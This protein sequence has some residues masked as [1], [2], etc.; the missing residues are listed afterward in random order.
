[1]KADSSQA[2]LLNSLYCHKSDPSIHQ[3][4]AMSHL[5]DLKVDHFVLWRPKAIPAPTLVIGVLQPGN[6]CTLV[7]IEV[8]S[9]Q[10][11]PSFPELWTL[12]VA[13]LKNFRDGGVYHYFFRVMDT[14]PYTSSPQVIDITDPMAYGVDWRLRAPLAG[15]G[16]N[17]DDRDP[18]SVI[19][20]SDGRLI[21]CDAGG[22]TPVATDD[23]AKID[24]LAPNNMCVIYELP[25]SWSREG[26]QGGKLVDVGSFRDVLALIHVDARPVNFSGI[27]ALEGR[28]HLQE[29]GI[30]VL[31]L[32]PPADSWVDRQWGYA[33]SNYFAADWDLGKPFGNTWSTATS[34]LSRLIESC[35]SYG[36]RFFVDM[37]M[38]FSNRS[39]LRN[40]N[41]SDFLVQETEIPEE[42]DPE[43]DSRQNWG[44][45]LFKYNYQTTGY[46]P[47]SGTRRDLYPARDYMKCQL[48]HWI[49]VHHIDGVRI[50]SVKTVGNW[51]FIEEF[52]TAGRTQWHNRCKTTGLS[53]QKK[54]ERFLV[55]AEI[56]DDREEQFFIQ[57]KRADG[58]WN[59]SFKRRVR[60]AILGQIHAEDRNFG[61][62]VRKM[63][64]CRQLGYTDLTQVV[65]YVGSHDVEGYR[66]ERL[67]DFLDNNHIWQKQERIQMAF[68]C[69][70]TAAGI[71]MI[72][73]GDEE[74][75][76]KHDLK[77][78]HPEKQMDAV[79]FER[80]SIPWRSHL[81]QFI[82]R[83]VKLRTSHPALGRNE[84]EFLHE[85]C[86]GQ[87]RIISW[88]R[89]IRDSAEQVVVVANFSDWCSS[90][91]SDGKP[92][93]YVIP[94]W[95]ALPNNMHWREVTRERDVPAEWA[96]REPLYPWEAKVYI[97]A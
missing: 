92:A 35:H 50:D 32:N 69:L 89:G 39:P 86:I 59:E 70:L 4:D 56:L 52:S 76:D 17:D 20:Y 96:G 24:T 55:V 2:E 72:L 54:N 33:T 9:L 81:F 67:Y 95:P 71:P 44:G 85:D 64:D 57:Q 88:L 37:A 12:H 53:S 46:D 94:G 45:D 80:M 22:E 77:I 40:L 11:H 48:T 82:A 78:L 31:E 23:P 41:F 29:L 34:D 16:Y 10:Q 62:M 1:M 84:T 51:D 87:R 13:Q 19:M 7:N 74:F 75:A 14:N 5:I 18:S 30:N 97:P 68:A 26:E 91:G 49:T 8:R 42:A 43:K 6:P 58:I 15:T 73:A 90:L 25:T 21:P 83:L 27:D 38:G 60:H 79:N 93:E 47:E 65:N 3:G 66:N 28:A 36:I 61:D 63:I